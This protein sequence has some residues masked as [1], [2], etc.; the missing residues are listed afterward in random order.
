VS[1]ATNSL[2]Q[3][4]RVTINITTL[5]LEATDSNTPGKGWWFLKRKG[6]QRS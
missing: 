5:T 1:R 3:H 4:P 2:S 6:E